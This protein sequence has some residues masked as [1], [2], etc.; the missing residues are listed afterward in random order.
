MSNFTIGIV[1]CNIEAACIDTLFSQIINVLER[2]RSSIEFLLGKELAPL[3]RPH[4]VC[5][6][7]GPRQDIGLLYFVIT[8]ITKS[9][10][11]CVLLVD[12]GQNL[13]RSFEDDVGRWIADIII[14]ENNI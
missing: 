2:T 4:G 3:S 14:G 10:K 9:E 6:Y 7:W 12:V 11:N 13:P 5:A 1:S 8:L